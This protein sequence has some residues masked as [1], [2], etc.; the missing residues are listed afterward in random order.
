MVLLLLLLL[1]LRCLAGGSVLVSLP[2]CWLPHVI[3]STAPTSTNTILNERDT[4][5]L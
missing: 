1:S 2:C 3:R 5:A 4:R